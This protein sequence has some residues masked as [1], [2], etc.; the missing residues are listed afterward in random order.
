MVNPL[1]L[2]DRRP[3]TPVNHLRSVVCRQQSAVA[4]PSQPPRASFP[5]VRTRQVSNQY[6]A[7]VQHIARG[8]HVAPDVR[9]GKVHKRKVVL[10]APG[11]TEVTLVIAQD[12]IHRV[13]HIADDDLDTAL[14][15]HLAAR[16]LA[17]CLTQFNYAAGEAPT[18]ATRRIA[19][20]D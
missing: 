4:A 7:R 5:A 20:P 18:T 2:K 16:C 19:T 9:G 1:S 12:N 3:L 14:F 17:P 11:I 15:T 8:T 13:N 6:P 10:H